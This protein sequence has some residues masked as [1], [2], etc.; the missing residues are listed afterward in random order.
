MT[1]RNALA[2]AA[3]LALAAGGAA[4]EAPSVR[5]VYA[6]Q[7]VFGSATDPGWRGVPVVEIPLSGQ[8]IAPPVG[9]EAS[10]TLLTA[11]Q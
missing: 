4:A 8:I 6:P 3:V 9:G 2:I 10:N 1:G 11:S 7:G 5:V